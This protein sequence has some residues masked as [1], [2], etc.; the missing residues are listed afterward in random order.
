VGQGQV[1][2][3]VRGRIG[4]RYILAVKTYPY[5]MRSQLLP[6]RQASSREVANEIGLLRAVVWIGET[7][8]RLPLVKPLPLEHFKTLREWRALNTTRHDRNAALKPALCVTRYAI[9]WPGLVDTVT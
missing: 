7:L 2:V 9:L 8:G 5:A 1:L 3:A 6:K 4:Q